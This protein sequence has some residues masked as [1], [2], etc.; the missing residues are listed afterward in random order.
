MSQTWRWAENTEY[1]PAVR[2]TATHRELGGEGLEEV[3]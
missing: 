1:G 3:S 2:L